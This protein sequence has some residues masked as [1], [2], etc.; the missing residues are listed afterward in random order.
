[1]QQVV[2][3]VRLLQHFTT[4]LSELRLRLFR[5]TATVSVYHMFLFQ[6]MQLSQVAFWI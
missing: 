4:Q 3:F 5:E 6:Q 1:M 2:V